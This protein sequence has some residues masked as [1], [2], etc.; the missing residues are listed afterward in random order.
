[1]NY[2]VLLLFKSEYPLFFSA[3]SSPK[4][5][6]FLSFEYNEMIFNVYFIT[7]LMDKEGLSKNTVLKAEKLFLEL[8]ITNAIIY[9]TETMNNYNYF[10]ELN[11]IPSSFLNDVKLTKLLR[12]IL[13]ISEARNKNILRDPIGFCFNDINIELIEQLA[14]DTRCI[15]VYDNGIEKQ[16]KNELSKYLLNKIGLCTIFTRDLDTIEKQCSIL[17]IDNKIHHNYNFIELK[18]I[19]IWFSQLY[20][21]D[22]GDIITKYNDTLL[23]VLIWNDKK[24]KK[25]E[26]VKKFPY[27]F[28]DTTAYNN[29]NIQ[30]EKLYIVW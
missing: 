11:I 30:T 14:L 3:L 6:E 4:V 24:L 18:N 26:I 8:D 23:S 21:C 17:I 16:R 19:K 5:K 9:E 13:S 28:F 2:A 12:L 25:M 29:D 20:L 1:M 15:Y 22:K 7:I 10:S 27:I